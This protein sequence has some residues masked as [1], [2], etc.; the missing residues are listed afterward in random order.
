MMNLEDQY[1]EE[2]E[3]VL[4]KYFPK[5]SDGVARGEALVLFAEAMTRIRRLV[6]MLNN[7]NVKANEPIHIQDEAEIT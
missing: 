3:E 4:D 5:D 7:A 6:I 2:L 1:K